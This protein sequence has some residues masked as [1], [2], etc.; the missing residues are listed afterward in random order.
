VAAFYEQLRTDLR[1]GRPALL[2]VARSGSGSGHALVCDGYDP[3]LETYHLNL[4]WGGLSDA[5]YALPDDVP[6]GFNVVEYGIL[7]IDPG[8]SAEDLALDWTDDGDV[9]QE[10]TPV[11][12]FAFP[13][14]G[15]GPPRV[16]MR[17]TKGFRFC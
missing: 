11:S 6:G 10:S 7:R 17:R 13:N 1:E 9:G 16:P 3:V 5:W 2:C 4:G 15:I 8:H 14:P 12:V